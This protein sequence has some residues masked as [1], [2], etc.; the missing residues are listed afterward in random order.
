MALKLD[1]AFDGDKQLSRTLAVT[2]KNVKDLRPAW[3]DLEKVLNEFQKAVFLGKGKAGSK[4]WF[5]VSASGDLNAWKKLKPKTIEQKRK[6][7][8]KYAPYPLIRTQ[9]LMKAFT[10]N[11]ASGAIRVK[12]RKTFV[13][14]IDDNEIPYAVYHHR[15][16][17]KLPQR[18]VLRLPR[19]LRKIITKIVQRHLARTG[20]LIRS[21][22]KG[23][24]R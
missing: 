13:W 17:N 23:V 7:A 6:V 9:K 22:L 5:G 12:D 3:D 15:G 18:K 14:G 24:F 2:T 21:N 10:Q 11:N 4:S 20:Q 8:G 16:G 19:N 1:I